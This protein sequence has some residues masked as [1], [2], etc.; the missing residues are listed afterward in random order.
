VY[1]TGKIA[2]PVALV[3]LLAPAAGSQTKD[4]RAIRAAG[5]SVVQLHGQG[6]FHV[7]LGAPK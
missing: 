2:T 3:A 4:E 6:P 5:P 7:L 1:R